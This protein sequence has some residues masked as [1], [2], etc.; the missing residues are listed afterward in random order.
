MIK[1]TL[2]Q[3]G[4][5]NNEALVYNAL[6]EIGPSLAG[7]ISRKTGLHRRTVYDTTEMLIKKGLIAYIVKNNRRLFEASSPNRFL[8]ILKEK[9]DLI[10]E[11]LPQMLE[12]YT[13]T[14][15]KQETNFYKG[16]EGLKNVFEDQLE[17][18]KEIL[19]IGASPLA[20]DIIQFD[21]SRVKHKIRTKIIFNKINDK[22]I[23]KIPL[24]EIKYLPEKYSSPLA[25]NI[26]GNKVALILWSEQ[27]PFAIVINQKEIAEGYRKY[28]ELMWK[29]AKK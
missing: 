21:K 1:E 12:F 13:S 15:E 22:K 3:A 16:K 5:T 29:S 26:Y 18:K 20:Y 24:S 7:Q 17:T 27:N 4:L 25:V 6:L 19:I 10:Q 11:A 9:Q 8:D 23:P 14:K 28:F 2:K